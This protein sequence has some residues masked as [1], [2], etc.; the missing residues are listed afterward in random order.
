[1]TSFSLQ[2]DLELS[3]PEELR[4]QHNVEDAEEL[5]VLSFPEVRE[6]RDEAELGPGGRHRRSQLWSD[7][8]L[9]GRKEAT[10][11]ASGTLGF[12]GNP[13]P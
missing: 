4:L 2:V 9:C 11:G 3:L 8:R 12:G 1:M 13:H 10:G 7:V 5:P 6:G